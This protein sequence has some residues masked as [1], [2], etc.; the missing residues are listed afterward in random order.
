MFEVRGGHWDNGE[1][2]QSGEFED[3][4]CLEIER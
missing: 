1:D 4:H 2:Q 3:G